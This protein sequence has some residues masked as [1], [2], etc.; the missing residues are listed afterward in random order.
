MAHSISLIDLS[1]KSSISE[2]LELA[3]MV[4]L[5]AEAPMY[6]EYGTE[7]FRKFLDSEKLR[8]AV[9]DGSIPIWVCHDDGKLTGMMA[10]R[11]KGHI[12]LAFVDTAHQRTGIGSMLFEKAREYSVSYFCDKMTVNSS[13]VGRPFYS[14]LG[15]KEDDMEQIRDGIIFTPMTLTL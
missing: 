8:N 15:F 11:D 6:P 5:K 10:V 2:A 12:C 9:S 3:W 7:N 1:D 14:S 4:F 13:I